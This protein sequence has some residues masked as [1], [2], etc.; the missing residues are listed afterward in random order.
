MW[1]TAAHRMQITA[2]RAARVGLMLAQL[3][4]LAARVDVHADAD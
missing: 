4:P 2:Y 1:C 3:R